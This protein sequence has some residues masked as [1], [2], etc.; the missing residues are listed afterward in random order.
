[1][2]YYCIYML[3]RIDWRPSP[4]SEQ[5]KQKRTPRAKVVVT[6][7]PD[8]KGA[9]LAKPRFNQIRYRSTKNTVP[10]VRRKPDA[11]ELIGSKREN[12]REAKKR[13]SVLTAQGLI[14]KLAKYINCDRYQT[15]IDMIVE[16]DQ[17]TSQD[18][19]ESREILFN[20]L[21]K[22]AKHHI[23]FKSIDDE[24][25]ELIH[26]VKTAKNFPKVQSRIAKKLSLLQAA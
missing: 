7:S 14:A 10:I 2:G 20:A 6:K 19:D 22:L 4:Y 18:R 13:D 21:N 12:L 3:N 16:Q 26:D 5:L 11:P 9:D 24:F 25:H 23:Y 17:I 8:R 1:M 15:Q